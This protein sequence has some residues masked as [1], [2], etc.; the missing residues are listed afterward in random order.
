LKMDTRDE[1]VLTKEEPP[2]SRTRFTEA[3]RG[4][5]TR[6]IQGSRFSVVRSE[7]TSQKV[8]GKPLG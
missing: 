2:E 1:K 3:Q 5:L 7:L 4:N 8:T 6:L